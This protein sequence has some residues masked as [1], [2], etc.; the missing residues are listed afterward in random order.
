MLWSE[1]AVL[2]ALW[3]TLKEKSQGF[4][5]SAALWHLFLNMKDVTERKW[6]KDL[7]STSVIETLR[8]VIIEKSFEAPL[9][10]ELQLLRPVQHLLHVCIHGRPA[11]AELAMNG[12]WRVR[13]PSINVIAHTVI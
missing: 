2:C 5:C 6:K 8:L 12:V 9:L 13:F 4:V 10:C 7:P 1:R 3:T 11:D